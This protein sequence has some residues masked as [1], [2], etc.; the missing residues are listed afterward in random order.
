MHFRFLT[1]KEIDVRKKRVLVREDLNVPMK[2]GEIL[3]YKRIDASLHTLRYLAEHDAKVI[4][5]SHL[6]RPDGKPNPKYSL[7]PVANALSKRLAMDVTFA[8]DVVG[9]SAHKAIDAIDF[10][11]IVMLE[12]VRFEP[13]EEQN[14]P[15]FAR[16]LAD[17]AEVYVNDAFGTAHRAHASTEGVAHYLPSAAGFLMQAEIAAL[18]K[19]VE[20][21][22]HPY[23]CVI[24]G[25]KVKDKVGVFTKLMEK[26]QAFCIGGGMANTFLAA[27]G[28]DV[29]KS[30][31]DDDL[32]PAKA[33]L[34]LATT[35]D[36]SMLLPVDAVVST[37]F[38]NDAGAHAVDLAQVGDTV[39][40]DIGPKTAH[41]YA[42][43][44]ETAKTVVFNGPMGVYEKEAY[45][46]GTRVI[47]EAMKHATEHGATTVVGGGDAAAAAEELGFAEYVTHVSTGGGATLEFL[48]GKELPGITA[49][50]QAKDLAGQDARR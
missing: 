21:P 44:I 27:R 42:K 35:R 24:G 50:E 40:L 14:D 46:E 20:D 37:S 31:R 11:Q 33:I 9:P 10:G 41:E 22:Q 3:D 25:A 36:V 18:S 43:V 15:A 49:L 12:N 39:I 7:K 26:V 6:G 48:E 32:E 45:R 29:G 23:V 47:G 2:D 34:Q 38:D 1:L 19:L 4:V 17:L 5:V 16:E 8:T 13:G 28:V 30:L